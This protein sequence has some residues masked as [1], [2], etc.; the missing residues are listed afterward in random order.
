MVW[1]LEARKYARWASQNLN[2]GFKAN[3]CDIGDIVS[4]ELVEEM[5][6]LKFEIRNYKGE[7]LYNKVNI[8]LT[9]VDLIS[10]K[11]YGNIVR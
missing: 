10:K 11:I 3:I 7:K 1:D 9:E 4:G 5:M 6:G 2:I 8:L